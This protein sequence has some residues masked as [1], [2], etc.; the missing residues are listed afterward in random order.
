M[1]RWELLNEADARETWDKAL[2]K[3]PDYTLFQTVAWGEY[4]RALGWVPLRWVACDKNREVCA[5]VQGLL[6]RYPFNTG[7]V[8][9]P[10]GPVGDI[11][12]C[13]EGLPMTILKSTG[14]KRAYIRFFYNQEHDAK[15][16][17]VLKS[18]NWSRARFPIN[19]GLSMRYETSRD[20]ASMLEGY[21]RNWRHNLRRSEKYSLIVR[22]WTRPDIDEMLSVYDSMQKFK[23]LKAQYSRQELAG[24]FGKLGDKLILYRCEDSS[25]ELVGFRGCAVI[26]DKAWELFAATTEKGRKVYASYA[27]FRTLVQH[28][29]EI[30]VRVYDMGGVDPEH[31][32]GT[33][34]FKKGTGALP[35][36]YLGEWDWS[37]SGW[38]RAV[39]NRAI[40]WRNGSL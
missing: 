14:I 21:S 3:F 36:E 28:C 15:S 39:A 16:A 26:A 22:Q 4:K 12:A 25:R 32:Q 6:R 13:D 5:M 34:N 33:Y 31:N 2:M 19:S 20:D 10:G 17:S 29:R 37:T 24:I 8:W 38:L 9:A 40:S 35:V 1:V 18:H 7:V 23:N 11:S 27:L 30:G